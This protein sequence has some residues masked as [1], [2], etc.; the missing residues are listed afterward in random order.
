MATPEE[1]EKIK[2]KYRALLSDLYQ[3]RNKMSKLSTNYQSFTT[4]LDESVQIDERMIDND[5]ILSIKSELDSVKSDLNNN[6]I[7]RVARKT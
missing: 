7:S 1:I 6:L 2:R 3:I 5:E 4:L